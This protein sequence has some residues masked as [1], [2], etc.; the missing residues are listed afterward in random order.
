MKRTLLA[1][2]VLALAVSACGQAEEPEEDGTTA[3]GDSPEADGSPEG[4]AT[5]SGSG[6]TA[7]DGGTADGEEVYVLN[8]YGDEEGF[9]DQRPTEYVA[10]EFTTFSD[11]EWDEWSGAGARGGG[12]VLGTWC[13]DQGCQDDPYDVEIELGEP[14]EADGTRYFSAYTVTEYDEDMPEEQRDALEQA[15]G[16]RLNVP[17]RPR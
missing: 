16:G 4:T 7:A 10:S 2:A 9:D 12:E 8:L 14:V 3:G 6:D 5:D 15:D 13:M 11:M 17:A 1:G